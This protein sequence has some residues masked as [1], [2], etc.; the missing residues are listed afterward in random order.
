MTKVEA[1]KTVEEVN[2]YE[3][4]YTSKNKKHIWKKKEV[5]LYLIGNFVEDISMY[6]QRNPQYN[7][8]ALITSILEIDFEKALIKKYLIGRLLWCTC[9]L[10]EIC[11]KD[12]VDI[13]LQIF[14][15]AIATLINKE[16]LNSVKLVATRCI[17]KYTRKLKPEHL[18]YDKELFEK[19][20]D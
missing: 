17:I 2:I 16:E 18:T 9:Q 8:K 6:R 14:N 19:I 15:T 5:A 1:A 10:A 4:T 7:L 13:N 12:Y 20:L 3:F 11:P